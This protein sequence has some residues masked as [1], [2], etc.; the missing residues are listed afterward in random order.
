[1]NSQYVNGFLL[2]NDEGVTTL[3]AES[4]DKI[5]AKSHKISLRNVWKFDFPP[6]FFTLVSRDDFQDAV[7]HAR[8]PR[9]APDT[10]S[11]VPEPCGVETLRCCTSFSPAF[12]QRAQELLAAIGAASPSA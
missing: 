3:H 9:E 8:G 7:A 1:M 4:E 10:Q 6:D 11:Y 2:T 5:S 12:D